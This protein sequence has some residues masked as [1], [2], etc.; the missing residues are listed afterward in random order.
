MFY[1]INNSA[2]FTTPFPIMDSVTSQKV[3][4]STEVKSECFKKD[5]DREVKYKKER[6]SPCN[7]PGKIKY[8]VCTLE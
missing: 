3:V 1:I 8:H 2:I 7:H 6:R 5:D 4:K